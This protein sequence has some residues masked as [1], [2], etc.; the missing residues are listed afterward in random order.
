MTE[1]RRF[2]LADML[3]RAARE[4]ERQNPGRSTVAPLLHDLARRAGTPGR[5]P[6]EDWTQIAEAAFG[7][8]GVIAVPR[9]RQGV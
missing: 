8:P 6:T 1:A 5:A 4:A 3:Y 9:Q 7:H 2:E